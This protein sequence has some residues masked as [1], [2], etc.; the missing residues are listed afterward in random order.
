MKIGDLKAFVEALLMAQGSNGATMTEGQQPEVSAREKAM[1]EESALLRHKLERL[2]IK[3][4]NSDSEQTKLKLAELTE[5]VEKLKIQLT[6]S[7][8][9]YTILVEHYE[10]QKEI[11]KGFEIEI[12]ETGKAY[13]SVQSQNMQLLQALSER[14]EMIDEVRTESKKIEMRLNDLDGEK[15]KVECEIETLK[16]NNGALNDMISVHE[17]KSA[18]FDTEIK[19]REIEIK[20]CQ[21]QNEM[22]KS[23][24]LECENKINYMETQIEESK[25]INE[26]MR[27]QIDKEVEKSLREANRRQRAENELNVNYHYIIK[28]KNLYLE[29]ER[30]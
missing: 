3:M 15:K 6:E 28:Y 21:K 13:E 25:Q 17:K 30:M 19:N 26:E 7:I 8:K 1:S 18:E 16:I 5:Q 23:E 29:I 12:E 14:D 10:K 11:Q 4:I 24:K 2:K 27:D 20:K 9:K 22:L